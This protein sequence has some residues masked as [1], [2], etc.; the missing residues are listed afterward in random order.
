MDARLDPYAV[1]G[2]DNGEV[3]MLRNAGGVITD[4]VIR[5][6]CLSQRYLGTREIILIHH[7]DCGLAKVQ[8]ADLRSELAAEVGAAPTWSLQGFDDAHED[9]RQS[10]HRLRTD[11]YVPHTDHVR[12][13][14]FDV[15]AGSLDEVTVD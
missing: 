1:L 2:L 15:A 5:S 3:H 7:T 10:I 12:G 14:V 8:E 11:P 4:D 6:L 13:F 9:V